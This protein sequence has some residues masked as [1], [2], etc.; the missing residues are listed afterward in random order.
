[1]SLEDGKFYDAKVTGAR[2]YAAKSEDDG[3]SLAI[4]FDVDGE[5]ITRYLNTKTGEDMERLKREVCSLGVDEAAIYS[6]E[7]LDN[8]EAIIGTPACQ[9]KVRATRT[10][11]L[12]VA[13]ICDPSRMGGGLEVDRRAALLAKLRGGEALA[14]A[15]P[16]TTEADDDL[17]PF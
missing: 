13:Y 2:W 12:T 14:P 17:L 1:V 3:D 11:K 16:K 9:I 6:E 8:P 5:R 7:F 10:G 4:F 15:A